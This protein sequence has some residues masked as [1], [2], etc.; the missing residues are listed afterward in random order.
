MNLSFLF[1]LLSTIHKIFNI[2]PN[3]IAD[4]PPTIGKFKAV[5]DANWRRI[6]YKDRHQNC[7]V[8]SWKCGN[9]C[10]NCVLEGI[11]ADQ[12]KTVYGISENNNQLELQFITGNNVGSRLYLLENDKYW[13]P[14]LLNKQISIDIDVSEIPCSLNADV[15]LVQMN[16]TALDN[17]GVGY[18]DAQCP[19]DIKYFYTGKPN[20][21]RSPICSVEIDLI[22]TNSES[23]V[24]TLHPCD[25]N[26]CDKIGADA[27]SYRQGYHNFYGKGKTIDTNYPFTVITQFIGDP[28]TEVKRY[29]K[30]KG[31]IIEHPGGSLTSVNIHKWKILHQEP[32]TFELYGGFNSLTKAIKQGMVFI[33]S[34]WDDQAAHMTWLDSGDR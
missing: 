28:L 16:S 1:Y 2:K 3:T 30:Q 20:T 4:D 22:E 11:T 26:Q 13:L 34:I 31:R 24:W 19:T 6:H 15:Y 29:Y 9:K 27:N 18:G 12:Y 25:G 5:L 10:D 14:N 17:L 7:F 8:G 23:L 21:N 33:V 32:N